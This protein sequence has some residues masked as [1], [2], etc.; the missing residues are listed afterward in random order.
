[1]KITFSLFNKRHNYLNNKSNNVWGKK[2]L[3][4]ALL[5]LSAF[6]KKNQKNIRID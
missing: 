1:M 6:F 3:P 2:I 4:Q 5:Y